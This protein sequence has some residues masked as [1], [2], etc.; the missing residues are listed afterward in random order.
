MTRSELISAL[1]LRFPKLVAKDAEVSV[2]EILDAI[3]N[4][5]ARGGRVEIRGFGSF[6]ATYRA[7]RRGRNPRTGEMVSIPGR[8]A[9]HFRA[10]KELR[11]R[12]DA[13]AQT[14]V[15]RQRKVA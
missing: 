7:P 5:L 2:R 12:I 8:F 4:S 14:P 13:R 3:A 1:A 9:P 6:A 10:G 11:A 15:E